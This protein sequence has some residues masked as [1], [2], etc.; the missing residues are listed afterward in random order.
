MQNIY[1]YIS[2]HKQEHCKQPINVLPHEQVPEIENKVCMAEK[3]IKI[4]TM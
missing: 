3:L 2:R 4:L 1:K